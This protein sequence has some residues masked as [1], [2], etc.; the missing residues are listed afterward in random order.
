MAKQTNKELLN[1][2]R[3][4]R[5]DAIRNMFERHMNRNLKIDFSLTEIAS[6]YGLSERTIWAII[7]RYGYYAD[8]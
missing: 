4:K 5:N 7:K 8:K 1:K 3:L 6:V 2:N